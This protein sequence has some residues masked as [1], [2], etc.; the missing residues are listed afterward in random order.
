[1]KKIMTEKYNPALARFNMV[2][3]YGVKPP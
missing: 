1:V 2:S 3:S